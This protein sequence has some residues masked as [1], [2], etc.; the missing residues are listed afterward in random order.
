MLCQK[1]LLEGNFHL[2]NMKGMRMVH[3]N[4]R[5]LGFFFL[6]VS[7]RI[8]GTKKCKM[9]NT[10]HVNDHKAAGGLRSLTYGK[11]FVGWE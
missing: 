10:F 11:E 4:V 1:K 2:T 3:K 5:D 6:A 8:G 9:L 7:L